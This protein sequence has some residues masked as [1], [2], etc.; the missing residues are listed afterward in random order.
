MLAFKRVRHR[1]PGLNCRAPAHSACMRA[2]HCRSP[3]ISSTVGVMSAAMPQPKRLK[4]QREMII[5]VKV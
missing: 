1:T 2:P 4:I 3:V 5:M